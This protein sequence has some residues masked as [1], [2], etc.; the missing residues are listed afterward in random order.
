MRRRIPKLGGDI[1]KMRN[2][3]LVLTIVAMTC[4][5]LTAPAM[6][7]VGEPIEST[8]TTTP[9]TI[10]GVISP[11]EWGDSTILTYSGI[12]DIMVW[13]MNDGENIYI[14]A[15]Y[16]DPVKADY[17]ALGFAI[18][19]EHDAVLIDG[20]EDGIVVS[21]IPIDGYY[22]VNG[23]YYLGI[24]DEQNIKASRAY[25]D[26]NW[27]VECSKP[28]DSGDI[29]DMSV[30]P[31][32]T[33][34]V[35]SVIS[36]TNESFPA[37][38]KSIDKILPAHVITYAWPEGATRDDAGTWGDFE[39]AYPYDDVPPDVT[40]PSAN[41]DSIPDDTDNVPLWGED[42]TLN[43]TVTDPSGVTSVTTNL[44]SIGGPE[45]AEMTNIEGDI[46]SITTNA[47]AGMTS[48]FIA[49]NYAPF[50]LYVNATDFYG[51]SNNSVA[52]PLV[53]V[54]NGDVSE[55]NE[56]TLF[57][58]MYL[59][60]WYYHKPDFDVINERVGDVSGNGEVTLFDAMYLS[61]WYYNKPGFDVLK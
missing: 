4:A 8:W 24:D 2:G 26:G 5:V 28:L 34:G 41:P 44:S 51:N 16:P 52:I 38:L 18:D 55:N 6:G 12:G 42:S 30:A 53:V 45:A 60:K 20:R 27:T 46:W 57:D 23:T 39:L 32:D 33:I 58:A 11:E 29:Q 48:P 1:K 40:N 15:T 19:P 35:T 10:D 37:A 17:D 3:I 50:Q 22:D 25:A 56:V 9:P 61:K 21:F 7:H 47:S 43:V 59:S 14:A 54:K 13:L 31:G 36:D 49:S